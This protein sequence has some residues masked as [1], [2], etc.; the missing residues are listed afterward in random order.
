MSYFT[1]MLVLGLQLMT[2]FKVNY[3]A[4]HFDYNHV[5]KDSVIDRDTEKRDIVMCFIGLSIS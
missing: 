5:R 4:N 1:I 2:I 3:L